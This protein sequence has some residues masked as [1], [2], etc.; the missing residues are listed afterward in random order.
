MKLP[1]RNSEG[2]ELRTLE[3][4]DSVFGIK[5]NMPALH[6]AF[7]TQRNNQRAGTAHTKTRGQVQGST[8]KIRKQKYT[9]RARQGGIRAPHH[10]GGGTVFGPL[11]RSYSQALPKKMRRLAIRSAISGKLA[12]GELIVIDQIAFTVPKTKEIVRILR[13]V[14]IERSALIVTG[15]SDRRVLA[16][17]RNLQ[18]TKVLPAAHLN[19]VDML[20]HT[21]VLMTEDAVRIAQQLWGAQGKQAAPAAPAPRK[22]ARA[23]RAPA[24]PAAEALSPAPVQ[25]ELPPPSQ[26]AEAKPAR[27][28]RARAP[29]TAAETLEVP[30]EPRA[31]KPAR[32][33]RRKAEPKAAEATGET[34]QA[35]PKQ[36]TR[37]PRK[38]E[39]EG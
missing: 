6:Q 14:G 34:A 33:P 8:A 28:S 18:K 37:R 7:V 11:T 9:G 19:V 35:E 30:V 13:N 10:V 36:R 1:V 5:P 15:E 27:P 12:D 23:R 39:G 21:S 3:V 26:P 20:N 31:A 38:S 25:E 4:D 29:K 22:T 2:K 24:E 16:S 32:A 17:V